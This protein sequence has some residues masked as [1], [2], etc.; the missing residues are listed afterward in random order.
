[1]HAQDL[2]DAHCEIKLSSEKSTPRP[3][4]WYKRYP[5]D[6]RR[7]TRRLS[8]AARGAYSD[9]IDLIFTEGG[10]I[11]D[12]NRWLACAL[13]CTP[14]QW[15]KVREELFAAGK[16][17]VRD[18]GIHNRRAE[19]ELAARSATKSRP[20]YDRKSADLRP[21]VGPVNRT[22]L[23]VING[24]GSTE[25]EAE[26][27]AEGDCGEGKSKTTTVEQAAATP[28]SVGDLRLL[29]DRLMEAAD[30]ALAN[31]AIAQA[32]ESMMIPLMWLDNGCDLERDVLPTV[33]A[34]SQRSKGKNIKSW[35][36]YTEAVAEA[37]ATREGGLPT[38]HAAKSARHTRIEAARSCMDIA[39]AMGAEA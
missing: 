26:S 33:R 23:N 3:D 37:R 22:F 11:P 39:L 27:E 24:G 15:L 18:G 13:H 4:P 12:D 10:P 21:K 30:G 31:L 19:E 35:K 34:V 9:I 17:F 5:E 7:G 14:R 32:L 29:R 38:V 16:L 2:D 20:T 28:P 25:A 6:Y 8:L 36:Y 1:M